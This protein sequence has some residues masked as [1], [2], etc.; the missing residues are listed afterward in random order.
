MFWEKGGIC[1]VA[2]Y[3]ANE[4][5]TVLVYN[6]MI[7]EDGQRHAMEGS[8]ICN[9]AACKVKFFLA[10]TGD[11]RVVL[12]DYINYSLVYSCEDFYGFAKNENLWILSRA[13]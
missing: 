5:G 12:T 10:Y 4:D 9:G 6:S 8:A 2:D 11:Y 1:T 3:E 13:Q 7:E